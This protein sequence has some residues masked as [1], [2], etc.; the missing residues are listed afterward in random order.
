M[1]HGSGA[2]SERVGVGDGG[3][4]V[5]FGEQNGLG[6]SP[7]QGKVT[8]DRRGKSASRP[9]SGGGSKA[10]G[11]EPLLFPLAARIGEAQIF[12]GLLQ[13]AAGHDDVGST[14]FMQA[15]GGGLH[16]R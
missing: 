6:N 7:A 10:L 2:A 8:G 12:R 15:L 9:V 5:R 1:M 3:G 16:L 11:A 4:D 13:L 14:Q